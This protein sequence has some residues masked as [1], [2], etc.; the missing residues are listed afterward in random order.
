MS[1]RAHY[2]HADGCRERVPPK[3]L[4]CKKHWKM[5]PQHLKDEVWAHYQP[6]QERLDDT[7]PAISGD[8]LEAAQAAVDAV[9]RLEGRL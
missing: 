6:G 4:M 8:Y 1:S 2:C 9:A 5:V 7:S 3:M